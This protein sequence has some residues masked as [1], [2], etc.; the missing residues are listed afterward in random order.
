MAVYRR[1]KMEE[2]EERK[3]TKNR[4]HISKISQA[5]QSSATAHSVACYGLVAL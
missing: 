1:W 2:R 5:E 4:Y 3:R